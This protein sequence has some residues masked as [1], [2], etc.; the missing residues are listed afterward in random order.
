MGTAMDG[1]IRV[2]V[3]MVLPMLVCYKTEPRVK[4]SFEY[5]S[6]SKLCLF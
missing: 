3:G 4:T 1:M 5:T 6:T 2:V